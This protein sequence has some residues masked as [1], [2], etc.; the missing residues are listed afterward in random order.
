MKL[1]SVR[2]N[3]VSAGRHGQFMDETDQMYNAA[4]AKKLEA[5]LIYQIKGSSKIDA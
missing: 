5:E 3:C 1:A 2:L 4:D